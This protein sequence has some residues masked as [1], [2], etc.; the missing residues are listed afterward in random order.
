MRFRMQRQ[1]TSAAESLLPFLYGDLP[2]ERWPARDV[3]TQGEP[4]DSFLR[5]RRAVQNGR[6]AEAVAL[7]REIASNPQHESR[8][9]LQAWQFLRRAGLEPPEEEGALVLGAAAEVAV[10]QGH[11]LLIGYRDGR[12]HYLNHAGGA[13]VVE[14]ST[15]ALSAA[16]DRWL[17]VAATLVAMLGV[18]DREDLPSLPAG[19]TRILILTPAGKRFGQG[20]DA[21]ISNDPPAQAFLNAATDVL[22]EVTNKH[23]A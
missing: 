22:I 7:W 4:W 23:P 14:D 19:H 10:G 11:D 9:V 13:I 2:V 15:P 16:L 5:A 17:L 18:W 20:P 21:A 6:E 8:H 3:S 1:P 12:T